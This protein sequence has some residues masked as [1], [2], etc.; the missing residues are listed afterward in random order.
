MSVD[1]QDGKDGNNGAD[2]LSIVWKGELK[3]PPSS[4]QKNWVYKD[5]DNGVVYIYD[6]LAWEVLTYDG[7]DGED[8]ADGSDGLSVFIT[9]NDS[10]T[11]PATP[12]GS[13]TTN[14]WHT[15]CTTSSMWISQKIASSASEGTWGVPV[16]IQGIDGKDG[17]DG[18]TPY[19]HVKYSNDAGKTFTANNGE[20]VGMYMGTCADYN[21]ADPTTVSSYTWVLIQGKDGKDGIDGIDGT[22]GINGKDG[23]SMVFKGTYTSHPSSP[24][25]GWAYYN[26]AQGKSYV[27]QNGSWYQ[28]TIDGVNGANGKDGADGLSIT[29]KGESANPPSSP[30][31]NWVYRD[32]DNGVVYIYNGSAWAVMT[33][34]GNDGQDGTNGTDGNSVYITYND[35]TTTPSTPTGNGTTNGWHTN[36]TS[37]SVWISQK[38]SSSAS[39]GTWGTPVKIKGTDGTNGTNGKDG[40]GVS[41]VVIEYASNT[42]TTSA[43]T[44]GWSTGMPD[45]QSGYYLWMR[46][47]VTY[48]D[49][50]IVYSTPVC[51]QS[52]KITA[53]VYSQYE[54]LK[55][56]F[57]WIVKSGTSET[58]MVLNE[59]FYTLINKNITLTADKINLSGYVSA[60]Q[61]FT[62]DTSGNMTATGGKIGN[63]T[64]NSNSITGT[65]IGMAS[66]S[67]GGQAFWAGSNTYSSAPFRVDHNGNLTATKATI[68]GSISGASSIQIGTSENGSRVAFEVTSGGIVGIG[69][70]VTKNG[71]SYPAFRVANN[72]NLKVGGIS[73]VTTDGYARGVAEITSTGTIY[74][75][76]STTYNIYT[77]ITE[78]EIRVQ[79]PDVLGNNSS[80]IITTRLTDGGIRIGDAEIS[81][82]H[83]SPVGGKLTIKGDLYC[84]SYFTTKESI[85]VMTNGQ[86][87]KCVDTSS[88]EIAMV[89][90]GTDNVSRYGYGSWS[91]AS[92]TTYNA[93]SEF[94]G[95]AKATLMAKENVYLSCNNKGTAR[96]ISFLLDGSGNY[97]FR[98]G[99]TN[100]DIYCGTSGYP[101]KEVCGVSVN[102]T[103][104]RTLKENIRYIS[105][106]NTINEDGITTMDCYNF[107]KN[108]LPIA[109]YNYVDDTMPKIGFVAQDIIYNADQTDNKIGQLIIGQLQC[110]DENDKLTYNTNNLYGVMLSA[111]Q[112]MSNKI[113]TLEA[114]IKELKK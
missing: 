31:K 81:K 9:Y 17:V 98:P 48:T 26:S 12:T 8:G 60:N 11:Q 97:V 76:S 18:K 111:M 114:E 66:S 105:N 112:V 83:I 55:N 51:D 24:Q 56:Q 46:T 14:G 59:N 107:I 109:T 45:Y 57:S 94:Q 2:G 29:W 65:N 93:G 86:S 88:R 35:S 85:G 25:N 53:D 61:T 33:H 22:D 3:D 75:C 43:P 15:N 62:I 23:V 67:S 82:N 104:D 99:N 6:G 70:L 84:N 34:D 7:S 49:D 52:W 100:K 42:S 47:K 32:T 72:G 38:I 113:E 68:T 89:H 20:T 4:P 58:S 63:F 30:Q 19:F 50:S 39:T 108:D 37:S 78:G 41:S 21:Q 77:M 87:F 90:I 96:A 27:Y 40:V 80:S 74:S 101:W 10:T 102:Q 110:K 73:K 13:G 1:G 36:C 95:G 69:D 71:Y 92:S 106:A 64:I 16:K 54:Q 103:S 91:S 79:S 28:M 44:S 5:S